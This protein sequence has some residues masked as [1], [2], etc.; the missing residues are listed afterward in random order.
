[1]NCELQTPRLAMGTRHPLRSA[2]A[3]APS[4]SVLVQISRA[5]LVALAAILTAGVVGLFQAAGSVQVDDEL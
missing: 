1:M 3:V 4:I 2:V 5:E